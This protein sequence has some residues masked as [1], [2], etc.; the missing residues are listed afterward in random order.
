MSRIISVDEKILK[1]IFLGIAVGACFLLVLLL[2]KNTL[3]AEEFDEDYFSYMQNVEEGQTME[4]DN[5]IVYVQDDLTI[6]YGAELIFN[7]DCYLEDDIYIQN[8]G[9]LT[10]NN[11][12]INAGKIHLENG[13]TL[14]INA[15][16]VNNG[17]IENYGEINISGSMA[18]YSTVYNYMNINVGERAELSN[19]GEIKGN[20]GL[21]VKGEFDNAGSYLAGSIFVENTLDNKGSILLENAN[22][23]NEG[24]VNNYKDGR[25]SI[26]KGCFYNES[27]ESKLVNKGN[28]DSS[29]ASKIYNQG[30][31]EIKAEGHLVIADLYNYNEVVNHGTFD[32][33]GAFDSRNGRLVNYGALNNLGLMNFTYYS[34]F[35]QSKESTYT[36]NMYEC[37]YS[38]G[39][40][41]IFNGSLAGYVV[42]SLASIAVCLIVVR[43]R[44][45]KKA[46]KEKNGD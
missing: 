30:L 37:V 16:L 13:A 26:V 43:I 12:L 10:I 18:N 21:N 1:N 27:N 6:E 41:A 4:V 28:F 31:V 36:G 5:S 33:N 14:N 24:E 2:G 9:V 19:T 38:Y 29:N 3:H 22:L 39:A 44:I 17:E 45:V 34:D 35:E 40:T 7:G 8:G 15:N 32:I 20:G 23:N 11:E 25:I 42:V 46:K